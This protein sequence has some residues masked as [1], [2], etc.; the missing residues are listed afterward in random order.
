MRKS[1]YWTFPDIK[2][3]YNRYSSDTG[4]IIFEFRRIGCVK[5][6]L[7]YRVKKTEE[8][9]LPKIYI[10]CGHNTRTEHR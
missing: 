7:P 8:Y 9:K 3:R 2:V 1:V 4:S 6:T 5:E 10:L